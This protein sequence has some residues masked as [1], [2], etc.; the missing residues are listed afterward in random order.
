MT[1]KGPGGH[2][3]IP[4]RNGA[5]ATLGRVLTTLNENRLPVHITPSV[6]FMIEALASGL[7]AESGEQFLKLLDP[8]LTDDILDEMGEPFAFLDAVLHNTVNAT[9][10]NGGLKGNVIP[11]EITVN[12]DI[13]KLPG[14]SPDDVLGELRN[15]LG[16]E[17]GLEVTY[18]YDAPPESDLGLYDT[19]ADILRH[20]D[21]SGTPAPFVMPAGTDGR[22]FDRL[23][24]QT[25]GYLPMDLP[26]DTDLLQAIHA[27]DER[28]PVATMDF[29]TNAIYTLLQRFGEG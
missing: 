1:I 25:Y 21:P 20:A 29:G 27:A 8:A 16:N 23:G 10:V 4:L 13:R 7:P 14:Q 11:S 3:S 17:V 28:I 2:G 5:M 9:I 22:F 24:I 12:L 19:L 26:P 15:L 6:R 18:H